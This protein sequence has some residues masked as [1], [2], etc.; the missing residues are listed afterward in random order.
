MLALVERSDKTPQSVGAL[1][2]VCCEELQQVTFAN[3]LVLM[4]M[5]LEQVIG[6][7]TEMTKEIIC[8]RIDR[9]LRDLP[10][11]YGARWLL[12]W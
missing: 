6:A 10:P 11:I 7:S 5:F 3:A 4:L 2:Y 12:A 8:S 9:F 1:F